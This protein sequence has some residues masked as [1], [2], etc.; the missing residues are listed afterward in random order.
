MVYCEEFEDAVTAVS[1][2]PVDYKVIIGFE[3]G[4]INLLEFS[5]GQTVSCTKKV[6]DGHSRRVNDIDWRCDGRMF[7]TGGED[8]LV[9]MFDLKD[10][11]C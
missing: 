3:N 1:C 10:I 6:L 9:R 11:I 7:V 8:F 2:S 4:G 5:F